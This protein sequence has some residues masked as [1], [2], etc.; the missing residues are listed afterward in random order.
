M[1]FLRLNQ[2]NFSHGINEQIR[3]DDASHEARPGIGLYKIKRY[4]SQAAAGVNEQ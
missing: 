2:E 3:E 4:N 1:A